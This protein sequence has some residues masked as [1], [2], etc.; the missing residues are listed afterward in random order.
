MN[1]EISEL[2]KLASL[3]RTLDPLL[4]PF[5]SVVL[6]HRHS[7]TQASGQSFSFI[8]QK[9]NIKRSLFGSFLKF[10]LWVSI[11]SH[12]LFRA[13]LLFKFVET[14]PAIRIIQSQAEASVLW[15][16]KRLHCFLTKCLF[17]LKLQVSPF[18]FLFTTSP[19]E[20]SNLNRS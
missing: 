3:I 18:P 10:H 17:Q 8:K 1:F 2:A 11:H 19:L 20:C 5:A 4:R 7:L 15:S 14:S 6:L 16:A 9:L 12:S 13:T